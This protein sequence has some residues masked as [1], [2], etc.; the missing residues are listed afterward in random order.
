MKHEIDLSKYNLYTDLTLER[1]EN[2]NANIELN[3]SKKNG[4]KITKIYVDDICS[5]I[6][7]KSI[8]NY[9]TIEFKDITDNNNQKN[10]TNVLYKELCN[11]ININNNDLILVIGLGN[12]DSTPD[13]LGTKVAD[14]IL[15]TNHIYELGLLDSKYS[16][17]CSIKPS[18]Y[19]KTGIETSTI[20]KS[21]VNS[22]KPNI[23]ILIDSLAS[24]SLD[25]LN[26]T[27]EITDTGISPGSGIGNN[28][29]VINKDK[30]GV[31]VI[32]IGVPTVVSANTLVLE[33]TK[34][35]KVKENDLVVTPTEID[36]LIECL[37][38]VISNSINKCL[39]KKK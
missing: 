24:S 23:V 10:V 5:K 8:G 36:F 31:D 30:L 22:I 34:C 1:I 32:A 14:N 7:N 21:I 37:S 26:K 9:T 33:L 19:A 2:N 18:V 29:G 3:I 15:V 12:I 4:I 28:R 16:R 39:E 17:V 20:I 11:Y 38:K 13:S 35:K 27:I 25:R 6:I